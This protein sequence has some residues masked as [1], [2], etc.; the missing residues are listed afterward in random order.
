M[1]KYYTIHEK[2]WLIKN[3]IM[4]IEELKKLDPY[5]KKLKRTDKCIYE[6][7]YSQYNKNKNIN[8]INFNQAFSGLYFILNHDIEKL[9]DTLNKKITCEEVLNLLKN[10]NA[11][12]QEIEPTQTKLF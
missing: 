4:E 12:Y 7:G 11:I 3:N 6:N 8:K 5:I 1:K 2:E 10:Q 9:K